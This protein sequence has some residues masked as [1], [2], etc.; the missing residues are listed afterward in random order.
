MVSR[1]DFLKISFASVGG[2]LIIAGCAPVVTLLKKPEKNAAPEMERGQ[3]DI[4]DAKDIPKYVTSLLIPPAMPQAASASADMDYYEIAMRQFKQQVLPPGLPATTVWSY[5]AANQPKTFNFP[6]YT[7]EA[8]NNRQVRIKWIN[9]LI[10]EQG[11]FLPHLLPIDQTLHWANPT[12]GVNGRDGHGHSQATYTGP[13]PIVTHVH[14]AHVTQESDGYPEAWYLPAAKD[15][16]AGAALEG[17]W[18]AKYKQE[19]KEKYGADWEPGSAIYQYPNQQRATTLWYHDHTLGLTR[20]NVYAGPAGFY[21]IRGGEDDQVAGLPGPAPQPGDA[22]N[23]KYYEIPL[24]IQDRTFNKDGSLFYPGNRAFF[25]EMPPEKLKIPYHPD[26]V[27]YPDGATTGDSDIP[28]M[29][30]PEFFG[31]TMLVNGHTWPKLEVEAR[32]YRFRVLNGC[33]ARFILLK[34]VGGNPAAR[35]AKST[36]PFWQIGSEGG[37]LPQVVQREELLLAPAERADV[38]VDFT[39]IPAGTELYLI[40]EGPDEPYGGGRPDQDFEAAKPEET[41]QVMKFVVAAPSGKDG[42]LPPEQLSLP[43]I[44]ALGPATKTRQVSLNEAMSMTLFVTKD[45]ED[46]VQ[47]DRRGEP[48]GPAGG[49]LGTV[50]PDGKGYMLMWKSDITENPTQ[51]EIED[52]ELNNF[53]VDGHPIHIHQVM[54][55]VVERISKEGGVPPRPAEAWETGWKDTVV[56]YPNEITRLRMKFDI[57]G[58]YVWHCHILEHEDNEMMRPLDVLPTK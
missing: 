8:Q 34:L 16:P 36:L 25:E 48:F 3:L 19:F 26:A 27:T 57:P 55:Q 2:T 33:N 44:Q 13:I 54:F 24:A 14:G 1:R 5:G 17:T 42:S 23:T 50:A 30:N 39:N 35:P 15:L 49:Y 20:A 10:D 18:Y 29:W 47:L 4:L 46:T 37:F 45:K 6:A 12:G 58:R 51:N 41:G 22:E 38:I 53:T 43:A 21:I 11:N 32:R 52:W 40:N 31:N 28:P 7:I 9:G 56:A